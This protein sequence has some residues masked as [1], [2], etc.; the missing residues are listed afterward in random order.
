MALVVLLRGVNVGGHRTFRPSAFARSL[1]HL[2]VVSIGAAGTFVVRRRVAR[3]ELRDELA[4]ALP[5]VAQAAIVDGG[6]ISDLVSRDPFSTS[7][8]G[9]DVVRFV[10]VLLRTPR[11]AP[12]T[13]LRLPPTGAW[14][15]RVLARYGR[16]VVGLYRRNMRAIGH[17]GTLDALFGA[18][19]T[20]R[21]WGTILAVEAALRPSTG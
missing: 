19:V 12:L 21:T 7:T 4:R 1:A 8:L 3:T 9:R 20:T 15:L 10:S 16:F 18:P 5:F 13:P 11:S 6:E 14:Q 17:L 2:D